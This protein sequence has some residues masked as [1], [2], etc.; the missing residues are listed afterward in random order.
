MQNILHEIYRHK[1]SELQQRKG[2]LPFDQLQD[3]VNQL[4]P[5]KDFCQSLLSAKNRLN[6]P[7]LI[8]EIKYASPSKGDF[9]V[10]LTPLDLAQIYVDNGATA[11]SVLTDAV[12]F[13]GSLEHLSQIT[14]HFPNVPSLRKDFIF[15]A[16]QIYEARAA[17]ASAVLLIMAMLSV[18]EIISLQELC[19][20]LGLTALIE[21]H[22][23]EELEK[24]LLCR[25]RII[26][27][28]N[29]N[30]Q[31]FSV[32]LDTC[33]KLRPLIPHNI[34]CV[35]ESGIH[36]REDV[37]RLQSADFDAILVGEALVSANDIGKKVQ[38][39]ANKE[40]ID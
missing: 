33:L 27:I 31:D 19:Q 24:A 2:A 29:R 37:Q 10:N 3:K 17:S 4:P 34:L 30:L 14:Q 21:V 8:A 36:T 9:H 20:K 11:L 32:N 15:D 26:G 1:K 23:E 18:E 5:A 39:I 7:G 13:K 38:E 28:N 25:P 22:N 12:Y 35:A 6:S 16:Y 40:V